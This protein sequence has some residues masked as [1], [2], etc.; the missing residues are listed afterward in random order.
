MK[1][2]ESQEVVLEV[3]VVEV[4][5]EALLAGLPEEE[6]TA[7]IMTMA[8]TKTLVTTKTLATTQTDPKR[9]SEGE[10][11]DVMTQSQRTTERLLDTNV[12]NQ[13]DLVNLLLILQWTESLAKFQMH[14]RMQFLPK[15]MLS[16]QA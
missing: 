15:R 4:E 8:K 13:Q 3:V 2:S 7:V 5:P 16:I 12:N 14:I 6:G 11:P 1:I 9:L 10:D